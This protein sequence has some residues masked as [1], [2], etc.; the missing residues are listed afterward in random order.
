MQIA[1]KILT[2]KSTT[3]KTITL[4]VE[5]SDTIRRVKS[6]IRQKEGI[7]I[8]HQHLLFAGD[9]LE[10]GRVLSEYDIQKKSTLYLSVID[11]ASANS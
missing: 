3:G 5:P 10:D 11:P 2:S 9:W 1:V 6:M 8:E 4:E 7:P